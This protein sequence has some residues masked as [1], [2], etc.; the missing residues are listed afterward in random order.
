MVLIESFPGHSA[1][2][3][4][5]GEERRLP[6]PI[7]F[8]LYRTAQ[9]ALTNVARHARAQHVVVTLQYLA[10]KA[11][12]RVVDDGDG[13]APVRFGNGL[14]GLKEEADALNGDSSVAPVDTGGWR[15]ECSLPVSPLESR[16]PRPR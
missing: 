4:V 7:E 8:T 12:I 15:L 16:G 13:C 1:E 10:A 14:Q 2:L 5:A 9:E 11:I 6:T 3:N